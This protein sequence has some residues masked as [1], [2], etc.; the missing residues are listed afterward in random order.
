MKFYPLCLAFSASIALAAAEPLFRAGF[1]AAPDSSVFRIPA[2]S[3]VRNGALELLGS[4]KMAAAELNRELP[5]PFRLTFRVRELPAAATG[6]SD[7]HWGVILFGENGNSLRLYS[8]GKNVTHLINLG[9]Q[10]QT[11]SDLPGNIDFSGGRW[12]TLELDI[13][14]GRFELNAGRR[15]I[16]SGSVDLG[17]VRKVEFYAF[18]R[19]AAFDDI[20]LLPREAKAAAPAVGQPVFY[21]AFDGTPDAKKANG[22]TIHPDKAVSLAYRPGLSGEAVFIGS[23]PPQGGIT[24][25]SGWKAADGFIEFKNADRSSALSLA[26]P[27]LPELELSLDFRR[28]SMPEGDRHWGFDLTGE[29]GDTLKLYTRPAGRWYLLHGRE[30]KGIRHIDLQSLPLPPGAA[31]SPWNR[32]TL[33]INGAKL[34]LGLNGKTMPVAIPELGRLTK[35]GIYSNRIDLELKELNIKGGDYRFTE[36]FARFS[37]AGGRPELSYPIPGLAGSD[38]AISFWVRPEWDGETYGRPKPTYQLLIADDGGRQ[39]L[40]DLFQWEWLRADIGRPGRDKVEMR[41]RGRSGWFDGDWQQVAVSW[42]RDGLVTFYWNGRALGPHDASAEEVRRYI[43][44]ADFP[45][46]TRLLVGTA[47]GAWQNADASYDELKLFRRPVSDEEIYRDYRK[48]MPFDLLLH[49]AIVNP[50]EEAVLSVEIAPPGT[51]TRPEPAELRLDPAPL[52]LELRLCGENGETVRSMRRSFDGK[53]ADK[54]DFAIG[55]LPAG[56]YRLKVLVE[57]PNGTVQRSFEVKSY[58]D[59]P[60]ET[61]SDADLVTGTPFYEKKLGDAADPALR[62]AGE[63][64]GASL[65]GRPYLEAAPSKGNRFSF[66]IDF[67]ESRL[68]GRPVLLEI[69]WPDD[70]PRMMGLYMYPETKQSQHRDRLQGG[71]QSG[72]EYPL[73]GKM[74]SVR[75]LFYPGVKRYHFE[76]R[77]LANGMP[78]AVAAVRL[79]PIEGEL[80]K[81]KINYPENLPHRQFGNMDEDQTFETNLNYDD[82]AEKSSP[83]RTQ[84]LTDRLLGYLDYTG[85]EAWNYPVLRYHYSY[86]PQERYVSN[87]MYPFRYAELAYMVDAMHRRGKSVL[88]IVN[89]SN[90]PDIS[91]A[92]ARWDE[93]DRRGMILHDNAGRRVMSPF[94]GNAPKLNIVHPDV[95]KL[96]LAH[97]ESIAANEGLRPGFDGFEYWICQFGAWNSLEQGYDDY[98]AGRFTADTG[99]AVPG[100]G[101]GRFAERYRFLTGEKRDEWLK[102]RSE[103]VTNLVAEIRTM[104][105]RVNPKLAL[106]LSVFLV[107]PLE[108]SGVAGMSRQLYEENGLDLSALAALDRVALVPIRQNTQYRWNFHWGKPETALDEGLY[109]PAVMRPFTVPGA[110]AMTVSYPAYFETWEKPLDPDFA[111]YFQNADVKPHGRFFLKELAFN[112][113]AADSQ[114]MVIGAQPLGT[115]G[116][117]AETR[118]FVRAY[119]ALPKLPFRSVPGADDPVTLRYLPTANGTYFYLVSMAWQPVTAA[120]SPAPAGAVDLSTG[121]EAV[122]PVTLKPFELK[123]FLVPGEVK[124]TGLA[125]TVPAEFEA[126]Y[127]QR[128]ASLDATADALEKLGIDCG[129]ERGTLAAMKAAESGKRYA[130]LHRLAFSRAMNQLGG[131]HRNLENLSIQSRMLKENHFAVNCGG[132]EFYR[133][134]DGTL[135]FPDRKFARDARYGYTGS[136]NNV[137]RDIEKVHGTPDPKL[138][139]SEAYDIDGYRFELPDGKY[140]LKLWL[141]VGYAPKFKPGVFRFTMRAGDK[142]LLKDFD[143][144]EAQKGDFDAPVTLEFPVEVKGGSLELSFSAP[145]DDATVR[146]LNALE[147]RPEK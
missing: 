98:T 36:S 8:R 114:R 75:Y 30:G 84:R 141:K 91:R 51:Y 39:R 69:V 21:A 93:Y 107:K 109:D 77:T 42:N 20:E 113:A 65:D 72:N 47:A 78:A 27:E 89:Y 5:A 4:G 143:L 130:E 108:E 85:Q 18:N 33:R 139:Q 71:I 60:A 117:E 116:R 120:P 111:G 58:A 12:T 136:Y 14:P 32:L 135:F 61:P 50:E 9:G 46:M 88:G 97:L 106:Y 68:N 66:T 17:T 26:L 41:Q 147:L 83:F 6:K 64:Q 15:L 82:A 101:E 129:A 7:F 100:A 115:L 110:A 94:G 119:S 105:D 54:F 63:P 25:G 122:F 128:I 124:F 95:R 144:Y 70:K 11:N 59:A 142:V 133:A 112:L 96:F 118:E 53:A 90:L 31:D 43:N 35:L 38:G 10:T 37:P 123:S 16:G 73:S 134:A 137:V 23:K 56:I 81:L 132:Y 76:A 104:L 40:L 28:T 125:V 87:G 99:I 131:K 145:T 57:T 127:R 74:Q 45:A 34:V 79:L 44:D 80:P 102:W 121:E 67:D 22:D 62:K 13:D 138:F 2:G 140:R 29:N 3:A 92:P 146:F 126:F 103:Q 49:N 86:Y 24:A 19:D 55:K 1:D 52:R 48:Y